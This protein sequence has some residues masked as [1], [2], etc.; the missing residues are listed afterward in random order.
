MA[1]TCYAVIDC[2]NFFVSCER[3][4]RPDLW[5]KPVIVLSG[6]DGC[7]V[8][9]SNEARA[10][11]IKM[12][13]PAF[14]L[15]SFIKQ[16]QITVF[17]GNFPLYLN[18]SRRVFSLIREVCPEIEPYSID[19]AFINLTQIPQ[20]NRTQLMQDLVKTIYQATHIPVSV[21]IAPTKTLAKLANEVVKKISRNPE[22]VQPLWPIRPAGSVLNLSE[23][24]DY[25]AY[26]TATPIE[27][28][29]GIG[30]QTSPK[31]TSKGILTAADF[32]A[33]PLGEIQNWLKLPGEQIWHELRGQVQLGFATH[34]NTTKSL[35]VSRSFGQPITS[36]AS[37]SQAISSFAEVIARKLRNQKQQT[38]R[39][40]VSL[41]WRV[42]TKTRFK[43]MTHASVTLDQPTNLTGPLISA[44]LQALQKCWLDEFPVVKAGISV[45]TM[46]TTDQTALSLFY[47]ETTQ[48]KFQK[49][50]HTWQK[51]DSLNH[52]YGSGL[53]KA[54]SSLK[55]TGH[56]DW[57]SLRKF[58][59]PHYLSNWQEL[60]QVT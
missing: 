7:V 34:T 4:F 3:V 58:S 50:N 22:T 24:A 2:N 53:I 43:P 11:G 1:E 20:A 29:W 14:E 55:T 56:V 5:K 19:E 49:L 10:L 47:D 27:A 15:R 40:T 17:S 8:A 48:Q 46:S 51:L 59:S 21:G 28:V 13:Q 16:H 6:N 12:G 42:Q 36:L 32:I 33:R 30:R 23:L 18:L 38:N 60:C 57:Q 25:S 39:V 44:A 26:L 9:R 54:G 31:L 41:A 45:G 37:T 52:K 35:M